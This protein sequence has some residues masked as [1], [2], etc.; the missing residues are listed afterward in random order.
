MFAAFVFHDTVVVDHLQ[1]CARGAQDCNT[2]T[3]Q[4]CNTIRRIE[5]WRGF[6]VLMH[7]IRRTGGLCQD[8]EKLDR[9]EAARAKDAG[10]DS[11]AAV[12]IITVIRAS[13]FP[14]MPQLPPFRDKIWPHTGV[15]SANPR[16]DRIPC[17]Q[18]I[19]IKQF[20]SAM[21][22]LHPGRLLQT[23][24]CILQVIER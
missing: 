9:T 19:E 23:G 16:I 12:E 15:L 13:L 8:L 4:L 24:T 14:F 10:C 5:K 7:E 22:D 17:H 3:E 21:P 11:R 1:T 20:Y 2:L 6:T 18:C